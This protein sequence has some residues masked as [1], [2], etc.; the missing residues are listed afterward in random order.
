[1]AGVSLRRY[2]LA[3]ALGIFAADFLG[4][5]LQRDLFS[6]QF[7]RAQV[8]RARVDICSLQRTVSLF[9]A[10]GNRLPTNEEGLGVLV[11]DSN[12]ERR[13]YLSGTPIDP[14]GKPYLYTVPG[15]SGEFEIYTFGADGREGGQGVDSDFGWLLDQASCAELVRSLMVGPETEHTS[16]SGR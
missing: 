15:R 9:T 8:S 5:A 6:V 13:P 4:Y 11:G 16:T 10:D 3:L 12:K 2:A 14:W 1:M 7:E